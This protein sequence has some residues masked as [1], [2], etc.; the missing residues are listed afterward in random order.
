MEPKQSILT[1]HNTSLIWQRKAK[2]LF[3]GNISSSRREGSAT[4]NAS[5]KFLNQKFTPDMLFCKNILS[6]PRETSAKFMFL[7]LSKQH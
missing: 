1:E 4:K 6:N 2:I 5:N 7:P 3:T